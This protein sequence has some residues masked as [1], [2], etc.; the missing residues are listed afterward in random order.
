MRS[1][2]NQS[3]VGGSYSDLIHGDQGNT[4]TTATTTTTTTIS[5]TT[6]TTTATTTITTTA[7]TTTTNNRKVVKHGS[8][9]LRK[10]V[11]REQSE[12]PTPTD[13]D[14]EDAMD[15]R[16]N[17][18]RDQL[19]YISNSSNSFKQSISSSPSPSNQLSTLS[20]LS[21]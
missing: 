14:N 21:S 5:T 12:A 7:T 11:K 15:E 19:N 2:S 6:T 20:Y 16:L 10:T 1:T 17:I 8:F 9:I 18:S 13:D 4:Y 3:S